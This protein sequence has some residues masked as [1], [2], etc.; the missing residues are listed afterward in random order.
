VIC[1]KALEKNPDDR[2][3]TMQ[4]FTDDLRRF[5]SGDVI[6]ARPV[7]L[8]KKIWRRIRRNAALSTAVAAAVLAVAALI[9]SL[10]STGFDLPFDVVLYNGGEAVGVLCE[11]VQFATLDQGVRIRAKLPTPLH[12]ILIALNSDG[13]YHLCWPEGGGVAPPEVRVIDYPV[14]PGRYFELKDA[15]GMQFFLLLSSQ[16]P[17]P[18]FRELD[19]AAGLK[20]W[21]Q[22]ELPYAWAS[23]GKDIHQ[24]G[25]KTRDFPPSLDIINR[26]QKMGRVDLIQFIAFPVAKPNGPKTGDEQGK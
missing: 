9:W 17:L 8:T 22:V 6:L 3:A 19:A 13:T 4:A 26:I 14:E 23:D 2:Y 16:D 15:V 1:L 24:F 10:S 12:C 20:E 18:T 5:L 21:R 7:G 11:D 25:V